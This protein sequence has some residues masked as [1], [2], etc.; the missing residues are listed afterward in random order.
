VVTERNQHKAEKLYRKL[1]VKNLEEREKPIIAY[2]PRSW[3][4]ISTT[5]IKFDKAEQLNDLYIGSGLEE[6]LWKALKHANVLAEREWEVKIRDHKYYLD[7]AVF[8][9]QGK[10]AIETDGYTIHYG[11]R[12]K[13][14]YDTWR[15][16][17]LDLADWDFLQYTPKHISE[18]WNAYLDQIQTKIKKLGGEES[19][20]EYNRKIA[21]EQAGYLIEDDFEQAIKR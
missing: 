12:E 17:E 13:I 11:S 10:F 15:R 9:K 21:E 8:C 3:A 14:D 6:R 16:N 5:K 2:R 20:D 19:P 18:D 7:F 1:Y 4:F